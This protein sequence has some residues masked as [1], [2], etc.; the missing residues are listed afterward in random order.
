MIYP[1]F[2]FLSIVVYSNHFP[3]PITKNFFLTF[4]YG[5]IT[6]LIVNILTLFLPWFVCLTFLKVMII[7]PDNI[8]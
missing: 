2:H 4:K 7:T 8:C 1:D 3:F 5:C 6:L